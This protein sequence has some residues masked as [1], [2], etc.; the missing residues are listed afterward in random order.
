M[1]GRDIIYNNYD[2]L[3]TSLNIKRSGQTIITDEHDLNEE[4]IGY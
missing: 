2:H 3:L 4:A 1:L